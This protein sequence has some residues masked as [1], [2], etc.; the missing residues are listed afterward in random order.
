M[1]TDLHPEVSELIQEQ[2]LTKRFEAGELALLTAVHPEQNMSEESFDA[3]GIAD[4]GSVI[5]F[6]E[7]D[8]SQPP[9][10]EGL[11]LMSAP[12]WKL[13]KDRKQLALDF[14]ENQGVLIRDD[15][16]GDFGVIFGKNSE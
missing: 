8:P 12:R 7:A 11:I 13:M 14:L 1:K 3:I 16:N 15:Q 9:P 10:P 5:A 4:N 2:N 6:K